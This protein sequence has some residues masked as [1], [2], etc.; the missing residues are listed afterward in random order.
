MTQAI[1]KIST[2]SWAMQNA[3]TSYIARW[4]SRLN[5]MMV[6]SSQRS[7]RACVLAL[8]WAVEPA[9]GRR[10]RFRC[11]HENSGSACL[12]DSV[13]ELVEGTQEHLLVQPPR[14]A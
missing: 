11:R 13:C 2:T 7:D 6:R 4:L 8:A 5:T 14:R 9:A 10:D 1:V 12:S 3:Q